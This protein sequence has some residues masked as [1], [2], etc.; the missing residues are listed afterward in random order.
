MQIYEDRIAAKKMK[1]VKRINRED[2]LTVLISEGRSKPDHE[3]NEHH[4]KVEYAIFKGIE[5]SD[6]AE[7]FT[8]S[9]TPLTTQLERMA[10]AEL[11]SEQAIA[12]LKRAGRYG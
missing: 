1:I 12:A 6:I 10:T 5:Y 7:F 8:I 9:T 2:G 3:D 4:Y 11:R